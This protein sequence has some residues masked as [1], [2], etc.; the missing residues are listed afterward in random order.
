MVVMVRLV[1]MVVPV[2]V[3]VLGCSGGVEVAAVLQRGFR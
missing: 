1:V 3:G 2:V